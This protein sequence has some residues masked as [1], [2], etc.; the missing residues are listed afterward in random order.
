[1][2]KE[3]AMETLK[4]RFYKASKKRLIL[5]R[6]EGEREKLMYE[7]LGLVMDVAD[8]P[9]KIIEI[10]GT[11]VPV[12]IYDDA[13]KAKGI[14]P[15]EINMISMHNGIYPFIIATSAVMELSEDELLGFVAHEIGHQ[16]LNHTIGDWVDKAMGKFSL[17]DGELIQSYFNAIAMDASLE[18]AADRVAFK[19]GYGAGLLK[20][21]ERP[22][23]CVIN[24]TIAEVTKKRVRELKRLLARKE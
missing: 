15:N 19:L 11:R 24:T 18:I 1:M 13:C 17:I 14:F 2:T 4:K 23:F 5:M 3:E 22:N 21:L 12:I 20:C 16:R 7:G 8:K 6:I 10:G 9:T